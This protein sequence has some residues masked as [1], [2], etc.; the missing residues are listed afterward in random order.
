MNE[1]FDIWMLLAVLSI[2]LFDM[3]QLEISLEALAGRVFISSLR[4]T[5]AILETMEVSV[6]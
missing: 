4:Q 1:G 6:M 5:K 2:F 3:Y